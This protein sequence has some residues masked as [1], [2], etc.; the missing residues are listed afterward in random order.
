MALHYF[1][2]AFEYLDSDFSKE[3]FKLWN[4]ITNEYEGKKISADDNVILNF[5]LPFNVALNGE[6]IALNLLQ[7]S[8]AISTFTSKFAEKAEVVELKYLIH[9]KNNTWSA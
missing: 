4:K 7:R 3:N 6:R 1:F 5:S 9:K 8:S 2:G